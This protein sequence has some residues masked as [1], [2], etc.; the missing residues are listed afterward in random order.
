MNVWK[1][2]RLGGNR[3]PGGS[4]GDMKRFQNMVVA[5]PSMQQVEGPG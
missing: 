4:E 5:K 1:Q 2:D 3:I